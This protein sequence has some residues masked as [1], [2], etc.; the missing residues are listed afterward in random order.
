MSILSLEAF[1]AYYVRYADIGMSARGELN[2]GFWGE[3][4]GPEVDLTP[5]KRSK[6]M[7]DAISVNTGSSLVQLCLLLISLQF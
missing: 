5:E 4:C 1:T 6:Y 3:E 2:F 7:E